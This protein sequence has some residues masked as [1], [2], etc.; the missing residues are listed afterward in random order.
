MLGMKLS[1]PLC[2]GSHKSSS[3]AAPQL[4]HNNSTEYTMPGTVVFNNAAPFVVVYVDIK[5]GSA[6]LRK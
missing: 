2:A 1:A 6:V 5:L 4:R 3:S